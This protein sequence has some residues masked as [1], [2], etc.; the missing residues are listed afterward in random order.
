MAF[1]K[2]Q[3]DRLGERLKAGLVSETDL[4]ELDNYRKAFGGPYEKVFAVARRFSTKKPTGRV[5]KS[6]SSIIDKLRRETIRLSQIQDMAG[7]RIVV[8]DTSEQNV[9]VG[10]LTEAFP[11][12]ATI[13]RR[14]HPSH[15]YRAVHVIAAVDDHPVEI[16]VRTELQ[17][18]W[19]EVSEKYSDA[20]DPAIKY[21]RGDSGIQS[22]LA[23]ASS[24]IAKVEALEQTST[25]GFSSTNDYVRVQNELNRLKARAHQH[26]DAL[27]QQLDERSTQGRRDDFLG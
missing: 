2:T 19:A 5:A 3:I 10:A 24:D 11:S 23:R 8:V 12:A 6:T 22:L 26:L 16:Q 4:I 21:G 17:H 14:A 18:R 7:C 13:D 20:I 9:V 27:V 15:G 1:S 25:D